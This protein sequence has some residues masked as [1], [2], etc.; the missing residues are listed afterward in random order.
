MAEIGHFYDVAFAKDLT[1][2]YNTKGPKGDALI[3]NENTGNHPAKQLLGKGEESCRSESK[4]Q[5]S[6]RT[7]SDKRSE[8]PHDGRPIGRPGT[9][10]G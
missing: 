6:F 10:F 5:E 3:E 1:V 2:C 4:L 9:R 7:Y 8:R